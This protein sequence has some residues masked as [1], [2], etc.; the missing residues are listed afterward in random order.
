MH[1]R[2]AAGGEEEEEQQQQQQECRLGL[3]RP[4]AAPSSSPRTLLTLLQPPAQV[5]TGL[6]TRAC[7]VAW[8]VLEIARQSRCRR[9]D[10]ALGGQS[11][12]ADG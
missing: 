7:E 3:C 1:G 8:T 2:G 5:S 11:M 9:A 12:L 6:G 10:R 4:P